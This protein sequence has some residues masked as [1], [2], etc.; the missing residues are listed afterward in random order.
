MFAGAD[1]TINLKVFRRINVTNFRES[2]IEKILAK[3]FLIERGSGIKAQV[4][5]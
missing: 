3:N 5:K 1:F 4:S 2:R